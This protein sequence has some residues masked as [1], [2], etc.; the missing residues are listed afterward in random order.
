MFHCWKS[1]FFFW[2]HRGVCWTSSKYKKVSFLFLFLTNNDNSIT[3]QYREIKTMIILLT[4]VSTGLDIP[5]KV[6]DNNSDINIFKPSI[7]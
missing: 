1:S 2:G 4:V 7:N 5:I 3:L 6:I